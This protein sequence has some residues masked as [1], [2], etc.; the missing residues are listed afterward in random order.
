MGNA[1]VSSCCIFVSSV[2]P[3]V[4]LNVAFRMT[5]SLLMMVEEERGS[6]RHSIQDVGLSRWLQT[7][8]QI[9]S[10]PPAHI[11]GARFTIFG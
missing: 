5:F 9:V 4:V 8:V 10:K 1:S 11:K 6:K 2:H 7:A 3:V